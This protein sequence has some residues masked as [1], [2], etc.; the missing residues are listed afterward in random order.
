MSFTRAWLMAP[1]DGILGLG[2]GDLSRTAAPLD[3]MVKQ[4]AKPVIQFTLGMNDKE[5]TT[6]TFGGY[7][8]DHAS[9]VIWCDST[10]NGFWHIGVDSVQIADLDISTGSPMPAIVDTGS[11]LSYLPP[12]FFDALVRRLG[13]DMISPFGGYI[14]PKEM[15]ETAPEVVFF[16][17]E[18]RLRLSGKDYLSASPVSEFYELL[19]MNSGWKDE[20]SRLARPFLLGD[21]LLRKYC[22]VYDAER[23]RVGFALSNNYVNEEGYDEL[24]STTYQ[25]TVTTSTLRSLTERTSVE[26]KFE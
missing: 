7:T 5:E 8:D 12:V 13:A 15:M 2:R 24:D 6:V 11:T 26:I 25:K 3:G 21:N 18:G 14:V 17:P 10:G 23:S 1:F 22:S 20:A 19:F 16:L 9:P 4:G